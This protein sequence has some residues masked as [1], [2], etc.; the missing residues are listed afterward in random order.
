MNNDNICVVVTV[1]RR[2]LVEGNVSI[3]KVLYRGLYPHTLVHMEVVQ[4]RRE[5]AVHVNKIA[6]LLVVTYEWF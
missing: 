2:E 6:L 1:K 5:A 3:T 4:Y